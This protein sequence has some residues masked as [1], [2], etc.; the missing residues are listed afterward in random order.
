MHTHTDHS[1]TKISV[2]F[3]H[4]PPSNQPQQQHSGTMNDSNGTL[5]TVPHS[6]HPTGMSLSPS[7][8]HPS[9]IAFT[10]STSL[11]YLKKKAKCVHPTQFVHAHPSSAHPPVCTRM[12]YPPYCASPH[13]FT[14]AWPARLCPP[15]LSNKLG[16]I[17]PTQLVHAHPLAHLF[18]HSAC[19]CQHEHSWLVCPP[20]CLCP[21]CTVLLDL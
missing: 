4:P 2:E 13:L 19:S 9:P 16:I 20:A 18:A 10:G 15:D 17:Y 11:K 6:S 5:A 21:L 7:Y 1:A 14:S 3:K 12:P 8:Q